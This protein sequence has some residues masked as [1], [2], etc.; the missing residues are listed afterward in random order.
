MKCS[1]VSAN[2]FAMTDL[3][4]PF[5]TLSWHRPLCA[6]QSYCST[7]CEN[8]TKISDSI[9]WS[10]VAANMSLS[11]IWLIYDWMLSSASSP[12]SVHS[13]V[14]EHCSLENLRVP[15]PPHWSVSDYFSWGNS[16]NRWHNF[17]S[18]YL[19]DRWPQLVCR[20][21]CCSCRSAD[22]ANNSPVFGHTFRNRN[23][24]RS[25]QTVAPSST[26]Q[27]FR[28]SFQNLDSSTVTLF[29]CCH[30]ARDCY[31]N[32]CYC[33]VDFSV[34][35]SFSVC[36]ARNFSVYFGCSWTEYSMDYKMELRDLS[37]L[38]ARRPFA[39]RRSR[40]AKIE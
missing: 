18:T 22:C 11:W 9:D 10:C 15:V 7:V 20:R 36:C 35:V 39:F 1:C 6:S 30:R 16:P 34:R 12:F 25:T 23:G 14:A 4:W 13:L 3:S 28:R 33:S 17:P 5:Q 31:A 27:S 21:I 26:P 32:R 19:R 24:L 38:R 2:H 29:H 37:W 40:T 8:S